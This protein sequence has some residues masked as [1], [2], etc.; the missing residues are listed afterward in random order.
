[1][2]GRGNF[3]QTHRGGYA[4]SLVPSKFREQLRITPTGGTEVADL[5]DVQWVISLLVAFVRSLQVGESF[6][7]Q[8]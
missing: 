7:V 2:C 1:M 6:R 5:R 8:L 4:R 3:K